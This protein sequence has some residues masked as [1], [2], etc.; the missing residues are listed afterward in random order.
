MLF[1]AD[2]IFLFVVLN[3]LGTVYS[4]SYSLFDKTS[5]IFFKSRKSFKNFSFDNNNFLLSAYSI[6]TSAD[7]NNDNLSDK[8]TTISYN[9]GCSFSFIQVVNSKM[10]GD[11]IYTSLFFFIYNFI[12]SSAS[13]RKRLDGNTFKIL[14]TSLWLSSLTSLFQL[15]TFGFI[16]K[17]GLIQ[18]V[19][20]MIA[21]TISIIKYGKP[22]FLKIIKHKSK[23]LSLPKLYLVSLQSH[24]YYVNL[25]LIM[26]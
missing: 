21:S 14:N 20:S 10:N 1:I 12:L 18:S 11:N 2:I 8:F 22:D 15:F 4:F 6:K 25:L 13:K 3:K 5:P 16:N 9:I 23:I 17:I 7:I 26:L 24:F 19:S